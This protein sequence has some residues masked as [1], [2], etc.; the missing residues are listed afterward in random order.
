MNLFAFT[1]YLYLYDDDDGGD[2][3][4]EI[5][6]ILANKWTSDAHHR[7]IWHEYP[8]RSLYLNNIRAFRIQQTLSAGQIWID[9]GKAWRFLVSRGGVRAWAKLWPLAQIQ[10][11]HL[12]H[13]RL[14][15]AR[16]KVFKIV[17]A[18]NLLW[19]PH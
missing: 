4:A 9:A 19:I 3:G 14:T 10:C 12:A 5:G 6:W 15:H 18:A 17:L 8:M 7:T 13:G 1:L 11:R 2:I 16:W